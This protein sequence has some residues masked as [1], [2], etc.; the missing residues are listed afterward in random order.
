MSRFAWEWRIPRQEASNAKT[1]K[2]SAK[3]GLPSNP[4]KVFHHF[5]LLSHGYFTFSIHLISHNHSLLLPKLLKLVRELSF[6]LHKENTVFRST[7]LWSFYFQTHNLPTSIFTPY[8]FYIHF[9]L[10]PANLENSAVTTR[11][12]KVSFH[13]TPKERQCQRTLKLPHNYTHLTR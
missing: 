1:S 3:W 9:H 2:I 7:T 8:I 13:S 5:F 12:E 6:L 11:L 10:H 4:K